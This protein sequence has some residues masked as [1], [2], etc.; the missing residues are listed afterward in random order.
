MAIAHCVVHGIRRAGLS[1]PVE[2]SLAEDKLAINGHVEELLREL[3]Q[4]YV[5]KAGKSYGQFTRDAGSAQV[6]SWLREFSEERLGFESFSR[7]FC[8]HLQQ[9]LGE[10]EAEFEGHILFAVETL[11]DADILFVFAL[12]H[13]E[14][15]YVDGDLDFKGTR[16]LDVKGIRLGAKVNITDWLTDE[17]SYLSVLRSR[18]DKELTDAFMNC[19]GFTDQRDV[20][21]ETTEFLDIVTAYTAKMPEEE[22]QECRSKVVDY[23]LEQDKLGEPVVIES[24]SEHVSD[25][26]PEQLAKFVAEQ[27]QEARP[28]LIPD[29]KQLRQFVRISGRNDELSMSFSSECLGSSI[30]YDKGTDSL[31]ITNI[32]GPL[33]MRLLQHLQKSGGFSQGAAEKTVVST[34]PEFEAS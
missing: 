19:M 2:L 23:C 15:M 25:S 11:A 21:A 16:Y 30:M 1:A 3:K 17:P 4:A 20:A 31:T 14:G 10:V 8:E 27:Q 28:A 34:E 22:A 18:G 32:P 6:A 13:S 9:V 29:R 33:K 26:A 12:Q 7:K 24:L 5:S